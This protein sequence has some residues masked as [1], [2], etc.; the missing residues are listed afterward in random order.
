M[1]VLQIMS[2][3]Y[4]FL[5]VIYS[6]EVERK[7]TFIPSLRIFFQQDIQ[8]RS[9]NFTCDVEIIEGRCPLESHATVV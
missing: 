1:F 2:L 9:V 5:C 4:T 6:L 8:V 3:Q 7:L